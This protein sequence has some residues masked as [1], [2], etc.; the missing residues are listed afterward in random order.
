MPAWQQ[1]MSSL[2]WPPLT[3]IPPTTSPSISIGHPPTKIENRPWCMFMMPNASWPGCAFVYVCVGRRWQ[4]AVNALLIAISTLV[5]LPLSGRLIAIGHPA[6]S[7]THTTE[8]TPSSAAL[9][10]AASTATS[11]SSSDKRWD[12]IIG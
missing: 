8:P 4:A 10:N 6:A 12:V 3:P 5:G 11:A 7:Q 1:A 2:V 9:A